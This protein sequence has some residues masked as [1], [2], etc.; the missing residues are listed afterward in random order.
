MGGA[1]GDEVGAVARGAGLDRLEDLAQLAVPPLEIGRE[2]VVAV[3]EP[4]ELVVARDEDRGREVAGRGAVDG[5]RDR[6][7]RGGQV[8]GEQPGEEDADHRRDDEDEQQQPA[9][10]HVLGGRVEDQEDRPEPRE[11]D[12]RRGH[13]TDRQACPERQVEPEAGPEV[14]AVA[15]DLAVEPGESRGPLVV[16]IGSGVRGQAPSAI[17]VAVG[18]GRPIGGRRSGRI[19]DLTGAAHLSHRRRRPLERTRRGAPAAQPDPRPVVR[20]PP[21]GSRRRARSGGGPGDW[22]RPRPSGEDDAS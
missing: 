1:A 10:R 6:P 9:E 19:V 12:E 7:E 15:D 16:D 3:G 17:V 18:S 8:G 2:A 22:D 21:A 11:R 5:G 14:G 20:R 13:E 4:G